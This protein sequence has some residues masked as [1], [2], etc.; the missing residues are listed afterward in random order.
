MSS[1]ILQQLVDELLDR[2]RSEHPKVEFVI[3]VSSANSLL[4]RKH[5]DPRRAGYM[6]ELGSLSGARLPGRNGRGPPRMGP[7]L[8]TSAWL[9]PVQGPGSPAAP[10]YRGDLSTGQIMVIGS[11]GS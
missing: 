6:V 5:A 10:T 7:D 9:S 11:G 2:A 4:L 3:V 8:D 1:T